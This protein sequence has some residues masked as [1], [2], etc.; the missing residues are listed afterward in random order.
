[1]KKPNFLFDILCVH[2]HVE[3]GLSKQKRTFYLEL[4]CLLFQEILSQN[5]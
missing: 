4:K 3:L 5:A 1:M 2:S